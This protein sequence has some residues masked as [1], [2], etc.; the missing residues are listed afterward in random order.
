[1][2]T[3]LSGVQNRGNLP[4]EKT[5]NWRHHWESLASPSLGRTKVEPGIDKFGVSKIRQV[6]IGILKICTMIS[7][8]SKKICPLR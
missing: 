6:T 7:N 4:H 1:M 5:K 2:D 3:N 8:K